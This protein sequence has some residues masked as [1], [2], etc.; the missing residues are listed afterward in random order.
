MLRTLSEAEVR[1]MVTEQGA[2]TVICEFCN[3]SYRLDAVNAG[4]LFTQGP[5]Q[6]LSAVHH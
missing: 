5:R 1:S 3:R 4:Q 2:V 6:A